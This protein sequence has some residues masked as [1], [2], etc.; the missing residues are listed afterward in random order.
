[1]IGRGFVGEKG[2][3]SKVKKARGVICHEIVDDWVIKTE[4]L[5]KNCLTWSGRMLRRF[6]TTGLIINAYFL[7]QETVRVLSGPE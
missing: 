5:M 6:A 3:V 1:M 7:L 4:G 2:S